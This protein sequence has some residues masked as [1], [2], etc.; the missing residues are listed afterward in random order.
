[1]LVVVGLAVA[2]KLGQLRGERLA[3][4]QLLFLVED[5][6]ALLQLR[7]V[8]GRLV[9]GRDRLAHLPAVALACLLQLLRVDVGTEDSAQPVAERERGAW[10][11]RERHVVRHRGPEADGREAGPAAGVVEDADDPRRTLV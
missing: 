8:G 1:W 3:R 2:Q 11:R 9:V 7:D 5:V 6:R 10:T 4:R